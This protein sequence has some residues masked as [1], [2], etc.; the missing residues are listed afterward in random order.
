MFSW[1]PTGF[2]VFQ[3]RKKNPQTRPKTSIRLLC[4]QNIVKDVKDS[5]IVLVGT[6]IVVIGTSLVL[7]GSGE[8]FV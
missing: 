6:S 1:E 4:V 7:V 3:T 5:C 8:H 2:Q